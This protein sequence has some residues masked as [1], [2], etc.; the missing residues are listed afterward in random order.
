MSNYTTG[1]MAKL[2]NVSVRTVQYYDTKGILLPSDLTEG[3]RRIYNDGDLRKLQLICTLKTIGLSLNAI[4]D[5]LESELSGKILTMLLDE[6]E[7][8]LADEIN[9]RQKQLEMINVIKEN[10]TGKVIIPANAILDIED[11]MEKKKKDHNHKKLA[12]VY[13]GVGVASALGLLFMGWLI[14]SQAWW[15][16][17]VYLFFA[18]FGL[19]ISALQ[20]KDTVFICPKCDTVFKPSLRRKFFSTGGNKVRWT[21]CPECG[22]KNW[23]VIRKEVKQGEVN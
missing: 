12:M 16:L 13:V 17:A 6:Q 22:H 23:C 14:R 9:E 4:K 7:V 8:L 11:A 10:I 1:E 15:G 20:L 19:F 21:Y 2:C 18:L 3:G 5:V